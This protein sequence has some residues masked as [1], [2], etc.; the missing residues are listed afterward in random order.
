VE[1][2]WIAIGAVAGANTRYAVGRAITNRFGSSFPY[3]TF[4]INVSGA[5]IIGFL[6]T[7]LTEVLISDPRL[8]LVLIVGFLGSYT[9][10]STFTYEAFALIDQGA[11]ARLM[12][13]VVG[14]N[15]LGIAACIAGV[16]AARALS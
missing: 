6:L 14:S 2:V 16:V 8:R 3:G 1:Y 15:V 13:Y 11:W 10:F 7:L 12:V 4:F 9:T 5:L